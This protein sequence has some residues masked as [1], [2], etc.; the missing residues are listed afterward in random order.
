MDEAVALWCVKLTPY[1][2]GFQADFCAYIVSL[3]GSIQNCR[4]HQA[5][6]IPCVRLMLGLR[7]AAISDLGASITLALRTV[8]DGLPN[9]SGS[10]LCVTKESE[11]G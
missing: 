7:W 11:S 1:S 5:A 6:G 4:Q 10:S 9:H 2:K 8:L 3:V